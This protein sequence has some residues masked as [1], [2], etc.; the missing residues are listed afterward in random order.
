MRCSTRPRAAPERFRHRQ[1]QCRRRSLRVATD[2]RRSCARSPTP[3]PPTSRPPSRADAQC[4]ASRQ[5]GTPSGRGAPSA[6]RIDPPRHRASENATMRPDRSRTPE[7]LAASAAIAGPTRSLC[8]NLR[9]PT[10]NAK[11]SGKNGSGKLR[12]VGVEELV[13]DLGVALALSSPITWPM[14]KSRFFLRTLSSSAARYSS[15]VAGVRGEHGVDD[16]AELACV[17]HLREAALL[18]DRRAA[19]CPRPSTRR[20]R[21][22]AWPREIVPS[23]TRP[24]S[25]ASISGASTRGARPRSLR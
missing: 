23:A 24:T 21:P 25:S 17:A 14:R 18:D 6:R 13:E 2:E 12:Q 10:L 3:S 19:T 9:I 20:A 4:A 7:L 1:V 22:C 16:R 8:E 15:T 11:S 5:G